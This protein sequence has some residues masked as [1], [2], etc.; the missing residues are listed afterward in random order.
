MYGNT[1]FYNNHLEKFSVNIVYP[2]GKHNEIG[3]I[4]ITA[5]EMIFVKKSKGVLI[6]L[7]FIGNLFRMAK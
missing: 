5:T 3:D 4:Y 6:A 7:G 2:D 1:D